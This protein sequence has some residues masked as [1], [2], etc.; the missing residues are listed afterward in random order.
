MSGCATAD[1]FSAYDI[2]DNMRHIIGDERYNRLRELGYTAIDYPLLCCGSEGESRYI[3]ISVDN[4]LD[5]DEKER[6]ESIVVHRVIKAYLANAGY[7]PLTYHV[8]RKREDL[9]IPFLQVFYAKDKEEE[10]ILRNR[11]KSRR[12]IR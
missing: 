7:S 4:L 1:L 10:A 8:W 3:A 9:H 2:S 11:M 5:K 12:H 6:I